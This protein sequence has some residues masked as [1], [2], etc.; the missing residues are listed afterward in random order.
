MLAVI[1][2]SGLVL[3][4]LPPKKM[5]IWKVRSSNKRHSEIT[6]HQNEARA[7]EFM[8]ML[9]VVGRFTG[10]HTV[11]GKDN[12]CIL[13]QTFL[14]K[15]QILSKSYK[16]HSSSKVI[17]HLIPHTDEDVSIAE[18]EEEYVLL[19]DV[20]EVGAL[21]VGEE[22]VGLPQTLEHLGIDGE[23]VGLEVLR[24]LQPRVVPAL[25]QEDVDSVILSGTTDTSWVLLKF[26]GIG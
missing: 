3:I 18:N 20:V 8:F 16:L 1:Q 19:G 7:S 11:N 13:H 5:N 17:W 2:H 12:F 23:R 6:S 26:S 10:R 24:Q 21:L 25:P 22:Q 15:S 14:L 9:P 4:L